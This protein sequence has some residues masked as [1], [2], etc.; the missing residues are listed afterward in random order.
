MCAALTEVIEMK[1]ST[2]TPNELAVMMVTELRHFRF[3]LD[4]ILIVQVESEQVGPTGGC[5]A[6]IAPDDGCIRNV[7]AG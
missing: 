3:D 6:T 1:K 5:S 4:D 2:L 7:S